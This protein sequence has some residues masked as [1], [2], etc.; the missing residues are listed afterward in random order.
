M[1]AAQGGKWY[2]GERVIINP[3]W[4]EGE[5]KR[6]TG[7]AVNGDFLEVFLEE[8][9]AT[10]L[11]GMLQRREIGVTAGGGNGWDDDYGGS[12]R[13]WNGNEC[14]ERAKKFGELLMGILGEDVE[15]DDLEE[16]CEKCMEWLAG[17]MVEM[18]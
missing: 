1:R 2:S 6:K 8:E 16:R 10:V 13:R 18:L 3:D 7:Y 4:V 11:K 9:G 17:V 14:E 12:F 15:W 5:E